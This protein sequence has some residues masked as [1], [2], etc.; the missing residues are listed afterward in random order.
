MVRPDAYFGSPWSGTSLWD[1]NHS[2]VQD[3]LR[4]FDLDRSKVIVRGR[5]FEASPIS[6]SLNIV[7]TVDLLASDRT[8]GES[9][10][11]TH[12]R[13]SPTHAFQACSFNHSD[14]SPFRWNQQFTGGWGPL[15]KQ[16][17]T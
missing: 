15:Q 12:G 9:G 1:S 6:N 8:G 10:I 5:F 2:E 4:T 14:I 3:V 16:T 13:V 17:V 11:R 7:E